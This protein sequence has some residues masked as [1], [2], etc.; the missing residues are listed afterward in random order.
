MAEKWTNILQQE[1]ANQGEMERQIGM[2]TTLFGGPPNL[3]D[4]VKKAN[5]QI[6]FMNIFALPLFDGVADLLPDMSFAANEIRRNQAA[7][8]RLID[9]EQAKELPLEARPTEEEIA[10]KEASEGYY[11]KHSEEGPPSW[12]NPPELPQYDGS[13]ESKGEREKLGGSQG[14]TP[15]YPRPATGKSTSTGTD[16]Y[17]KGRNQDCN[18]GAASGLSQNC[19]GHHNGT[20]RTGHK[21]QRSCGRGFAVHHQNGSTGVRT[22]SASTYTNNTIVTPVSSTTQASSVVSADSSCDVDTSTKRTCN[23]QSTQ[24]SKGCGSRQ[25]GHDSNGRNLEKTAN[26]M[27]NLLDKS[28]NT[29][30]SNGITLK[31]LTSVPSDHTHRPDSSTTSPPASQSSTTSGGATGRTIGRRRSRLR[32]AFWRRNKQAYGSPPPTGN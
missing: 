20:R 25:C 21:H 27:S 15:S 28:F 5:G 6:A 12:K 24:D 14:C 13:E 4:L 29:G 23:E 18:A 1:F 3:E 7:W 26:F 11:T 16:N 19:C 30:N 2:E 31:D 8:Q 17:K 9:R 22:Q 10:Q 32:L